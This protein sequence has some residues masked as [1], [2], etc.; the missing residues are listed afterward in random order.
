[1]HLSLLAIPLFSGLALA[2]GDLASLLQSQ[3]DLS[4]L[5]ELVG[6]V[7]GLADTLASSTNITIFAPTNE[8]FD[9]VPRDIPEGEAIEYKNDSIAIG[10]LLA[11]HVF[12]GYYP[13]SAATDLPLFAQ[14]LLD[15]SYE[16]FRQ[17]FSNFTGGQYNGLVRNG[18]D[19]CVLS[20]E[21]TIS[22][23]TEADIPLGPGI[24]IHKIDTV[25]SFGAPFQLFTARAGLL[26]MNAA[27]EAAELGLAFG[28][29]DAGAPA[30]NISDFTIFVPDDAA[31]AA[32]GSVLAEADQETLR[33]VL[34]HH[35]IENNVIFSP[36]LGN[37]SVTSAQGVELVF[38][39]L[40]DGSAWVNNARIT[41][42]NVIL[43]NGVA[44]IIDRYVRHACRTQIGGYVLTFVAS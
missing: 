2:Q 36:S 11:N 29:V 21:E 43:F 8:A 30:V 22:T 14:T 6:L 40:P 27:V 37:V 32:I 19:V 26:A 5:L 16:N 23:V 35:M 24:I 41:L 7:D 39:V 9:S 20:G 13:A 34:G 18:D 10:A 12:K 3:P 4:T 1:M 17:P 31:F 25:L 28:E 42:P 44:H 38:T 33:A 15:S